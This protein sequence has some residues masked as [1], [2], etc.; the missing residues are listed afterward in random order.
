MANKKYLDSK[1]GQ[2]HISETIAVL[3]IFFVLIVFG[4]IFYSNYQK[5]ALKEKSEELLTA[6]AMDTTLKALYLPE[7]VCTR[8]ESELQINCMD[9]MKLNSA[10]EVMLN[11][12]DDYYEQIFGYASITIYRVYPLNED[13]TKKEWNIY[14]N[15][16]IIMVNGEPV[17]S[18]RT[19]PTRFVIALR[20]YSS[21]GIE[22]YSFGY[23]LVEVY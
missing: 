3:F 14:N 6:R 19:E 8:R 5:V 20:N 11:D 1:Q 21:D 4:L 18:R 2:I 9:I 23:V 16:K 17:R 15:P 10:K 13:G 7:L 22:K 12:P